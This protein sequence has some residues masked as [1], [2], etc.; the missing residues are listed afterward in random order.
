MAGRILNATIRRNLSGIY[1]VS[2]LA[3]TK[4]QPVEKTDSSVGV[5][6]GLKNFAVLS[7]GTTYN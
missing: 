4:V 3:E 2:I 7:D 6:V 1:F 5:E